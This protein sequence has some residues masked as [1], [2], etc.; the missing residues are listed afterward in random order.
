MNMLSAVFPKSETLKMKLSRWIVYAVAKQRL[1]LTTYDF[2]KPICIR[3]INMLNK[4]KFQTL[5]IVFF[6]HNPI[7]KLM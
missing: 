1:A 5:Y 4:R 3:A 6:L 7:R 2:W